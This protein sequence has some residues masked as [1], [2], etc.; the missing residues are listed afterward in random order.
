M[1]G[2]LLEGGYWSAFL[3]LMW[4]ALPLWL[5]YKLASDPSGTIA[6]L[7]SSPVEFVLM[8]AMIAGMIGWFAWLIS[9]GEISSAWSAGLVVGALF[10]RFLKGQLCVKH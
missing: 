2:A 6:L 1:T 3:L 8:L 10:L 7:K 9:D 5:V 4:S